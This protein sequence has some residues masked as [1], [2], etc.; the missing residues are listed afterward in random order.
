MRGSTVLTIRILTIHYLVHTGL[1]DILSLKKLKPVLIFITYLSKMWFNTT[2]RF[3]LWSFLP[4]SVT[5]MLYLPPCY[6]Y[7][8]QLTTLNWW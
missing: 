4:R 5:R 8:Q 2:I 1:S 3:M 6:S 7:C